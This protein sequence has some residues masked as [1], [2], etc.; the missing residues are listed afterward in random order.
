MILKRIL[1]IALI[2]LGLVLLID[3]C[4][5]RSIN[6]PAPYLRALEIV[7][8]SNEDYMH[9]S[10][11]EDGKGGYYPCNGYIFI[12]NNEALI[13][14]T[15]ITDSLSYQL[16]DYVNTILKAEIKGV[17]VNQANAGSPEGMMAFTNRNIDSYASY[18]TAKL[19]AKD[20]VYIT[21][22]FKDKQEISVGN[23]TVENRFL[24][25]AFAID[26]IVSYIPST[27]TVIGGCM[28]K[29]L[30]AT[31]GNIKNANLNTW[32]VTVA[33]VKEVYPEAEIV[34][35]GHGA[36]GDTA[37]LDYTISMFSKESNV[38]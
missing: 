37:L 21:Y 31:R 12:D 17:V 23:V 25:E 38:E 6:D 7:K 36:Y 8:L 2:S 10:Y 19:L 35:P 1:I 22:P 11:K 3:T 4:V 28:I 9:I 29:S 24:G 18:K 30:R 27:K 15:P 5:D 14:D 32:A 33:A 13:F 34:I 16:I 26:N 20:S